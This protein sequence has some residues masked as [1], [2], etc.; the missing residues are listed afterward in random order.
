VGARKERRRETP[1]AGGGAR[2]VRTADVGVDAGEFG[3]V[4][5]AGMI[6][7]LGLKV[8]KGVNFGRESDVCWDVFGEERCKVRIKERDPTAAIYQ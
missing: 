4:G 3:G 7:G 1:G 2:G 8:S 6:G 5:H